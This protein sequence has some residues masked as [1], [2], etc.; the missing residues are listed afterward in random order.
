MVIEVVLNLF[1]ELTYW[2]IMIAKHLDEI[3]NFYVF[4]FLE[5]LLRK[6]D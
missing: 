1:S 4:I 5:W 2:Q 3:L 6:I